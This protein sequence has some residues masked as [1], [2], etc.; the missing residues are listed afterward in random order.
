MPLP[1]TNSPD[2]ARDEDDL[3]IDTSLDAVADVP[4]KPIA[5]NRKDAPRPYGLYAVIGVLFL[6]IYA[7]TFAFMMGRWATDPAATH[8]WLVIPIAAAVVYFK[9][10][11]LRQLPLG[12]NIGGLWVMAVALLMHLA[13]KAV[14]LN[15]PSPLSIPL[16]VGG[17]VWYFAGTEWLRELSFPIGYLC[18]MIPI[19]GGLTQVVTFPLQLMATNGSKFICRHLGVAVQGSGVHMEFWQPNRPHLSA[20]NFVQMEIAVPCSGIHSLMAIKALHAITAYLS[21]LRVG[22]KWVLFMCAI[23]VAL[24][25]NLCRIVSIVLV[26]AYGN[27]E[28]GLG[29]WHENIAPY[30]VFGFAIVILISLGRFMEWA[31]GGI[32]GRKPKGG[33]A[34]V[35]AP[36]T[37]TEVAL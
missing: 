15:G 25:A 24:A 9:R 37:Q 21:K 18:F 36:A 32:E 17:A 4:E 27:K 14:D 35:A 3:S 29:M 28:F 23:P 31:T 22:W 1:N 8:G 20:E 12:S 30:L 13:E 7:T 5:R 11:R 10:E 19:P 2:T 26:C 6:G 34:V 16:F 33:A